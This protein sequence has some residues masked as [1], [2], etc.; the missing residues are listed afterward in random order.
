M[1]VEPTEVDAGA[2]PASEE[3]PPQRDARLLAGVIFL[4]VVV[5]VVLFLLR[6]CGRGDD[7]LDDRGASKTIERVAG[8]KP[9]PGSVSVWLSNETTLEQALAA[10]GVEAIDFLAMGEGRYIVG[11]AEGSEVRAATAIAA[12]AGVFDTGLV[13]DTEAE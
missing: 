12:Q 1:D 3:R 5:L 9:V 2:Q 8:A 10:S 6:D 11:V 13:Y 4:I 7:P